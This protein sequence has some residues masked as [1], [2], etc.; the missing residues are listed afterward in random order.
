MFRRDFLTAALTTAAIPTLAQTRR[1]ARLV[2]VGGAEDR[3]QD[4]VILRRFIEYSGG[5]LARIRLITAASG[6]PDAVA[7][8]YATA[9]GELGVQNFEV[10]PLIDRDSAFAPGLREKILGADGIFMTGGD[11]SRLMSALWETPVLGALHQAFHL[12]GCCIGGTSAGAAVM[13]RHMIS[14]GP[15]LLRP[16]KDAID[17][18]IG[19]GLLPAAIV[20]QHFSERRRLPRLLS[21]LAQRPDLLGVGVDEDTALVVE[22]GRALEVVGRGVVTLVD[23]SRVSTNVDTLEQDEQ[24]EMLGLQLHTLPAGHRYVASDAS[25]MPHWPAGL[26]S[27]IERLVRPGPVR[28]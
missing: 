15:A 16:R 1:T 13:S 18:D 22:R 19:L 21:A 11:Q 23:P 24:I 10:L 14:Q 28:S 4:R 7:E 2:I 17:T 26:R 25:R 8:S 12:R 5:P 9:F 3:Q 20:D 6:V 27:A